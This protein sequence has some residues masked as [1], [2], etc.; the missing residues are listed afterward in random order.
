MLSADRIERSRNTKKI[1]RSIEKQQLKKQRQTSK[2]KRMQSR[3][4]AFNFVI[5]DVKKRKSSPDN[6]T[7]I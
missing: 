4:K 7:T 6:K 2:H 5:T 3:L 1:Q